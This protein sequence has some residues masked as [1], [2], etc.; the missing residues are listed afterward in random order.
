MDVT[1]RPHYH[2]ASRGDEPTELAHYP[3]TLMAQALMDVTGGRTTIK[4]TQSILTAFPIISAPRNGKQ[5]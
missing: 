5:P 1:S 2:C 3:S 4:L